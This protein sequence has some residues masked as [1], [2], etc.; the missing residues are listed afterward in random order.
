MQR[1]QKSK[2]FERDAFFI[3]YKLHLALNF[4]FEFTRNLQRIYNRNATNNL[5]RIP[6]CIFRNNKCLVFKKREYLGLSNGVDQH[7]FLHLSELQ[8]KPVWRSHR[9]SL[10]HNNEYLWMDFVGKKKSAARAYCKYY[11]E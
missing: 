9:Q 7:D 10:L 3:W 6:R 11:V 8:G 4:N 1:F 5:A 2:H